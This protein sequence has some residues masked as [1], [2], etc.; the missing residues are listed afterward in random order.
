[1]GIV[2]VT[3]IQDI[4]SCRAVDKKKILTASIIKVMTLMMERVSISE[5][6][7]NFYENIRRNIP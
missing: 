2:L 1:M 5:T 6:S 7:V 4:I 3:I